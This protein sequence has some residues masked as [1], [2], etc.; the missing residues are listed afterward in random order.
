MKKVAFQFTPSLDNVAFTENGA[1]S[2]ATT[3]SEIVDQF[4]KAG[5]YRGRAIDDVFKDQNALWVEDKLQALRF[6]FYLR[7][8]TRKVKVNADNVTETVQ[9][10]QGQRDESFKRLLWFAKTDSDLLYRNIWVLPLVGSWKDLWTLMYYD[11]FYEV[12]AINHKVIFDLLNEG[13]KSKCHMELIKKFMPRIKSNNKCKTP[14]TQI[15]NSLAREFANYNKLAYMDYNQLKTSGTA[16]DFQK[17]ICSGR[18]KDINW[19]LIPGK[20]LSLIASNNFLEKHDLVKSYTDWVLSQPT[21]K[22]TGYVYELFKQVRQGTFSYRPE[23]LPIYKRVTIDRQFDELIKKAKEDGNTMGNVWC[24]LDTSGSMTLNVASGTTAYD[25]CAS[26]GIFFST[27]NEGAFHKSVVM[28]DSK[29]ETMKLKGNFCD[30]AGQIMRAKTAFGNTDFQSVI[31]LMVEVR[32]NNPELPLE[33]YCSTILVVSD[34]QFDDTGRHTTNHEEAKAKLYEVFPK[35]FVD[36]MKFIWW[37]VTG[38]TKDMPATL[39]DGGNYF[40]SGFDGS[41]ITLL[42]G[43]ELAKKEQEEKKQPTMEEL[44]GVALGQEILTFVNL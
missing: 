9:K 17:L 20:A 18:Y 14:W 12:N 19:N 2:Y 25:V 16:H 6:P 11:I 38:R 35:E 43:G 15:T 41:V 39:E 44:I 5:T 30:M 22:F 32:K 29:S 34:M 28:F 7:M 42:L 13:L 31:D 36:N 1:L 23:E 4:G 27:L 33:E 37:Q 8:I 40:F 10:G 26:L 21:V 24:A 3:G